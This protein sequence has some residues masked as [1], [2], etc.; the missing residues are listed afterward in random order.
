MATEGCEQ[1]ESADPP[2]YPT[3]ASL[4]LDPHLRQDARA[5]QH[6]MSVKVTDWPQVGLKKNPKKAQVLASVSME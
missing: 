2:P 1:Q 3:H 4:Q 5:E 6:D